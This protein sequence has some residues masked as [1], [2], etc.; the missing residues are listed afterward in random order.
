MNDYFTLDCRLSCIFCFLGD[1]LESVQQFAAIL[2]WKKEM[3]ELILA[4]N[5]KVPKVSAEILIVFTR[6]LNENPPFHS[7]LN[8]L[9]TDGDF[10]KGRTDKN[11]QKNLR[12]LKATDMTIHWKV[13]EEHVLYELKP[14]CIRCCHFKVDEVGALEAISKP[15]VALLKTTSQRHCISN[16]RHD[17][18]YGLDAVMT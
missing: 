2:G 10:T 6:V 16:V 7:L 15:P 8:S 9:W 18:G 11:C 17:P 13:L 3:S 14:H 12:L 5:E 4:G 1:L